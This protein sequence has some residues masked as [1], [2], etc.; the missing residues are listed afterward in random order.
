MTTVRRRTNWRLLASAACAVVPA[1]PGGCPE[2]PPDSNYRCEVAPGAESTPPTPVYL[3]FADGRSPAPNG[4]AC[5]GATVP[6]AFACKFPI[7]G[8]ATTCAT[9]VQ[10]YLDR[11]FAGYNVYFTRTPP[12]QTPFDT[13][14]ITS[15]N[16]WCMT[17]DRG[18]TSLSCS[19]RL[20]DD[21]FA[22]SCNDDP[23]DC[24]VLISHEYGHLVGLAHTNSE[25]DI[26][27]PMPCTDCDG[28]RNA[29]ISVPDETCDRKSQNSNQLLCE[30]LGARTAIAAPADAVHCTDVGPPTVIVKSPTEGMVFTD[31]GVMLDVDAH[32][33]CGVRFVKL[34]G[35]GPGDRTFWRP[36]YGACLDPPSGDVALEITAEDNAGNQTSATVHITVNHTDPDAGTPQCAPPPAPSSGS[37]CSCAVTDGRDATTDGVLALGG[38]LLLIRV[39]RGRRFRRPDR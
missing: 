29:D 20:S 10:G 36:P 27:F 1:C 2:N 21:A 8:D 13:V 30:A 19:H 32:D 22:L 17:A 23:K 6:P 28:F 26:M 16:R 12:A 7:G 4:R 38:A 33:E 37:S 39:R 11:W 5:A 3:F 9:Q 34:G 18:A 24:A 25:T 15:D 14:V 31:Q 35:S